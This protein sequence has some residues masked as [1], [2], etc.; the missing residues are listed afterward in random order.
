VENVVAASGVLGVVGAALGAALG[1]AGAAPGA[2]GA[3][4]GEPLAGIERGESKRTGMRHLSVNF[5]QY[6]TDISAAQR[7][8]ML[9]RRGEGSVTTTACRFPGPA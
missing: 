6:I 7:A 8:V 3:L 9:L 1:A 5:F 2:L 4:G